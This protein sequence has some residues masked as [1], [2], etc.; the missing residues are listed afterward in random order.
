[1]LEMC[2]VSHSLSVGDRTTCEETAFQ[3]MCRVTHFLLVIRQ[4]VMRAG[5]RKMCSVTYCLMVIVGQDV[6]RLPCRKMYNVSHFLLVTGQDVIS[7]PS[8]I[9]AT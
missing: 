3:K 9:C 7:L 2:I 4:D 5:F 6:I 8:K 1:M